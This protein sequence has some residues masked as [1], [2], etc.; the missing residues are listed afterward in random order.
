MLA[1][2]STAANG[3]AL[4]KAHLVCGQNQHAI[5]HEGWVKALWLFWEAGCTEEISSSCLAESER[6][7]VH[8]KNTEA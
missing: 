2:N 3:G 1:L 8:F 7:F 5:A 4:T 6:E